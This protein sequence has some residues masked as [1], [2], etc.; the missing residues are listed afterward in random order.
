MGIISEGGRFCIKRGCMYASHQ[1]KVWDARPM[2]EGYY[3]LEVAGLKAYLEPCLPM[4]EVNH[5]A[6][7]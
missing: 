3:I 6:T 1:A 2:E 7:S 4:V 5:L